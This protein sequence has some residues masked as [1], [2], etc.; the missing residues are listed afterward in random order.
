MKRILGY[1]KVALGIGLG[2]LLIA[3]FA[4]ESL[5]P[6]P[7]NAHVMVDDVAKTYHSPMY[8]YEINVDGWQKLRLTTAEEAYRLGYEPDKKSRDG[9]TN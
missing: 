5:K 8:F 2:L 1:V 9:G 7:K 6:M 4:V 3:A